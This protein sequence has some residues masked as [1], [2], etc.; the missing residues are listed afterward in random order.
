MCSSACVVAQRIPEHTGEIVPFISAR[1]HQPL[2]VA[3]GGART[4]RAQ[5]VR[6]AALSGRSRQDE[7][8]EALW[9][10]SYVNPELV[11]K[12]ILGIRKVLG[13]RRDK[14]AF[15]ETVQ[16]RGYK[17][18]APVRDESASVAPGSTDGN[19]TRIVGRH[20]TRAELD[21][22][23]ERAMQGFR[24]VFFVTGEAG[25]GKTALIDAFQHHAALRSNSRIARGQCVEV[26]GGKEAYYPMLEAV[27]Q[28]IRSADS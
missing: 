3:W 26:F 18:I 19:P 1:R 27:G 10:K 2:S 21:T 13:D 5:G 8:L 24:Q 23:L 15:I 4:A 22:C 14:P 12:Y 20:T 7:I 6:S 25:A 11:K 16:K 28:L 17:F 9:S